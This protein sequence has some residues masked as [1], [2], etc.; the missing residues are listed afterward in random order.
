[1]EVNLFRLISDLKSHSFLTQSVYIA[2]KYPIFLPFFALNFQCPVIQDQKKVLFK[3]LNSVT[4]VQGT[5]H[6]PLVTCH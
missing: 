3:G 6:A 2:N 1:M 4:K 5:H